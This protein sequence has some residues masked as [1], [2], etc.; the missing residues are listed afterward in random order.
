MLRSLELKNIALIDKATIEFEKGL[1]VLSGETGSGKSVIIDSINFVLGAKADKTMIRYGE[2]E[3][4]AT[5]VFDLDGA[6]EAKKILS[7]LDVDFT[8]EVIITRKINSESKSSIRVNGVPFTVGMLK[9]LTSVLVDVHG[10]SEHYSLLKQ[11]EQLKVLDKFSFSALSDLKIQAKAVAAELRN[12]DK[13][14]SALGGNESDRA[15]RADILK[16]QISE[17]EN[18][19]LK[20]GE[21]EEL[22]IKRKKLRNAEKLREFSSSAADALEGEN[23]ALDNINE[24]IRNLS[25]ISDID[26]EYSSA[27][28][29]LYSVTAEIEDICDTLAKKSSELDFDDL[30]P[31]FVEDRIDKIKSLY[32]KYGSGVDEVNRFLISAKEE[33]E[34]LINFD[35]EYEKLVKSK[36]ELLNTLNSVNSEISDLR[37]KSSLVFSEKVCAELSELGMKNAKFSVDFK[38]YYE[39]TD[40]PYPD[41]GNDEIEFM[42]SANLGEPSKPLSKIISG[43]EMS[44]FMLA[45]KAIITDYQEISTY[46]FDEIDVGISGRTAETVAEKLA[47]ISKD[48]QVIAISHLPQVCAFADN[49]LYIEKKE[50]VGKTFTRVKKLDVEGKIAEIVRITGGD[51]GSEVSVMHAKEMIKKADAF[52]K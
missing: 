11:S 1:N 3:S 36:K 38:D 48:T 40:A 41:N 45:L 16:F 2:T 20:D 23:R 49:S 6:E 29:R 37:R 22:E 27:A 13:K 51:A 24:A 52:K 46:I 39:I 31:D 4:A 5:A 43:G 28:D 18:A 8:D 25:A 21:L 35:E 33:Y 42:F 34:R 17:I 47:A 9:S 44:R 10:Q 12:T 14:I 50:E 19:E 32:K 26:E 30:D 15:I 7:D